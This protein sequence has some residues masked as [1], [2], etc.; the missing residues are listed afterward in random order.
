[1]EIKVGKIKKK[2]NCGTSI[3]DVWSPLG[4]GRSEIVFIISENI[5]FAKY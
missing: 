4:M 5:Q 1:M 3:Q 2:Q